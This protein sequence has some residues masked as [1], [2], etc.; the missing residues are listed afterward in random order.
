MR[1][2]PGQNLVAARFIMDGIIDD[3]GD[4]ALSADAARTIA[5]LGDTAADALR[6]HLDDRTKPLEIRRQIPDV[7]LR[8][9]TPA[10]GRALAENLV[11]TDGDLRSKVIFALS[12]LS[13]FH[14][15]LNVD[16][17][18]IESAMMA[19]MMGHYRSY[20][21]LGVSNGDADQ[22][23]K[24]TMDEEIERIFRLMKLMFPSLDLQNA[25]MGIRSDDPVRHANALEFLDN[26]L[27]PYLRTRLV[28]LIDSEVSLQERIKLADRFLGFSAQ[29]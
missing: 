14:R 3:L 27:N 6:D 16:K 9:G 23:L 17:Q 26:T 20:Q 8:I 29:A 28:P 7:L 11:Q 25:Y 19:E 2:G 24:Q 18:L 15:G 5:L 22:T 13:G 1:P 12:K 21:I 10:A 4:P